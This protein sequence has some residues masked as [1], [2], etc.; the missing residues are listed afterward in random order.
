MQYGLLSVGLSVLV[1]Y[2]LR[3]AELLPKTK[4]AFTYLA[5]A[6]LVPAM[7][8]AIPASYNGWMTV[9]MAIPAGITGL[10][11]AT[12]GLIKL[13]QNAKDMY[14]SDKFGDF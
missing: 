11:L 5:A 10:I 13:A 12:I 14:F 4:T 7:M 3:R 9:I 2:G 6:I 8:I 1:G